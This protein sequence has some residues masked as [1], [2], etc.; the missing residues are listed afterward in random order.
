MER[1]ASGEKRKEKTA[2]FSVSLTRSLVTY[3]TAQRE[4][5]RIRRTTDFCLWHDRLSI[6][7][8]QERQSLESVQAKTTIGRLEMQAA[9]VHAL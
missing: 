5:V 1:L 9:K 2:P 6:S 8:L 4:G 3:R 7:Q